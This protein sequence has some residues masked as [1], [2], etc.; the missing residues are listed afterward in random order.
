MS[1]PVSPGLMSKTA[2]RTLP[3]FGTANE[4]LPNGRAAVFPRQ[5]AGF[6]AVQPVYINCKLFPLFYNLYLTNRA[7][8]YIKHGL[9]ILPQTKI[10]QEVKA[11]PYKVLTAVL[12]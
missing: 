11:A 9:E 2:M 10:D 4:A 12:S 3:P 7:Q 8:L 5:C 1:E 6:S